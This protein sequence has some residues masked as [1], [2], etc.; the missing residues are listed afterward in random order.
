MVL[1]QAHGILAHQSQ[2]RSS[3]R[4]MLALLCFSHSSSLLVPE[5]NWTIHDFITKSKLA[6]NYFSQMLHLGRTLDLSCSYTQKL[7]GFEPV[8]SN[9]YTGPEG[10]KT[11]SP[12][13]RIHSTSL[14]FENAQKSSV[15]PTLALSPLGVSNLVVPELDTRHLT[16]NAIYDVLRSEVR[17]MQNATN[18]L[19]YLYPCLEFAIFGKCRRSDCGRQ[20]VNSSKLTDEQRQDSF[21]LRARALIIQLQIIQV[22]QAQT[23]S[24]EAERRKFRR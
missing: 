2:A 8:E 18:Q 19:R 6:I 21:N 4:A 20:E 7:L 9:S 3:S 23:R 11:T 10:N 13:F 22:Y 17:N 1:A 5:H 12:E 24:Q 15:A 14:M 16:I